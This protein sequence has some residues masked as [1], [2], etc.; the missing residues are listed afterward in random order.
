[1]ALLIIV[2]EGCQVLDG[3]FIL[4]G[5]EFWHAFTSCFTV[6]HFYFFLLSTIAVRAGI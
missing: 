2:D 6:W 5:S 3:E 1:M 4:F